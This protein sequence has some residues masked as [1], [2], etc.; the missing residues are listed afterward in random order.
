MNL[1][2]VFVQQLA[3]NLY[4]LLQL[5]VAI[6]LVIVYNLY[7]DVIDKIVHMKLDL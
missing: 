2:N 5:Y 7:N 4:Y 6:D 3:L 1:N